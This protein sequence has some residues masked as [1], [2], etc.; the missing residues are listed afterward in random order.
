MRAAEQLQTQTA[1]APGTFSEAQLPEPIRQELMT[2]D[3]ARIAKIVREYRGDLVPVMTVLQQTHGNQFV[4]QVVAYKPPTLLERIKG[5]VHAPALADGHHKLVD[6]KKDATPTAANDQDDTPAPAGAAP[7]SP[8]D[9]RAEKIRAAAASVIGTDA[10]QVGSTSV[11]KAGTLH[12]TEKTVDHGTTTTSAAAKF[13]DASTEASGEA[14]AGVDGL[15]V[16]GNAGASVRLLGAQVALHS[17][18]FTHEIFGEPVTAQ[19][20]VG[21]DAAVFTEAKGKLG[22]DVGWHGLGAEAQITGAGNTTVG[23]TGAATLTW[24]KKSPADYAAKI[25]Q[26]G[27]WRSVVGRLVPHWVLD[28]LS[29]ERVAGWLQHLVEMVI[30]GDGAGDA[31]VLGASTTASAR[32]DLGLPKLSLA[33][34][35]L[36]VKKGAG[37]SFGGAALDVD[38][39][40]GRARGLELL[41]VLA[42]RGSMGLFEYLA[43]SIS[44]PAF[45]R[46]RLG[47]SEASHKKDDKA[48][49]TPTD[50][51]AAGKPQTLKDRFNK[52]DKNGN[53]RLLDWSHTPDGASKEALTKG[54]GH[55]LSFTRSKGEAGT[56]HRGDDAKADH[57]A[58]GA[59]D[60]PLEGTSGKLKSLADK[61][62]GTNERQLVKRETGKKAALI[63]E[64]TM[65]FGGEKAIQGNVKG[66]ALEVEGGVAGEVGI[67]SEKLR[68]GG[69][70]HASAY[71]VAGQVQI[72]TPDLP[73]ELFG[74]RVIGK[75]EFGA[76]AGAF[77]EANGNVNIDVGWK[78]GA[79]QADVGGFAGVKAGLSAAGTLKWQ[80][81]SAAQYADMIAQTGAWRAMFHGVLPG[82]VLRAVPDKK[83]RSWLETLMGLLMHGDAGE[84]LVLG[85]TA[86][87][88]GSVG[89]GAAGSFSA[90]FRGGVLHCHGRGGLTFGVGAGANVD[91]ALGLT[92]GMALL[93]VLAFKGAGELANVLKP[94]VQIH[95][96][97][98]PL[99][100]RMLHG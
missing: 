90:G 63:Q 9:P 18:P 12:A 80:R 25:A 76:D 70:A 84:A 56:L 62:L 10:H 87:A 34:G 4:Q 29:D 65:S 3:V 68:I 82:W 93:G 99:V 31:V 38:V 53:N 86:R 26:A 41:S 55:E 20:H 95:Q 22:F 83:L 17:K 50:A 5:A 27:S 73:L 71:L 8:L 2:D 72:V 57:A 11:S 77:A 51:A 89:V 64:A 100:N 19:F 47:D 15:K 30:A 54:E 78:G 81:K 33:G 92:D 24:A 16:A 91:L 96:H 43:P 6:L 69:N 74:E 79:I 42:F 14:S 88:E 36:H 39:E 23:L 44:I 94:G 40:L 85:A 52:L 45:L 60:A 59:S 97:I 49:A 48:D 1:A 98:L 28:R 75:F 35:S 66:H 32:G 21:V 7:A 46:E 37:L 58:H 13:G 61:A 67:S